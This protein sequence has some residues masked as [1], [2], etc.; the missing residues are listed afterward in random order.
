VEGGGHD[1]RA[2]ARFGGSTIGRTIECPG[3]AQLAGDEQSP[4][5]VYALEGTMAHELA[6]RCLT[7]GIDPEDMVDRPLQVGGE[8]VT[9]EMAEAVAVHVGYVRSRLVEGD[10]LLVEQKVSLAALDPPEDMW[11]MTDVAIL[12]PARNLL[13]VI[14][15]KHGAGVFVPATTP[16]LKYYGIGTLFGL[17]THHSVPEKVR[18]TVVQPRAFSEEGPIRSVDMTT[19]ELLD[20]GWALMDVVRTALAPDPPLRSGSHCRFCPAAAFCPALRRKTEDV[21]GS[22]LFAEDPPEQLPVPV[23]IGTRDLADLLDK[24]PLVETWVAAVR[25]RAR[26]V[27][28]AGVELPGWKLVERRGR[29]VW[30]DEE[31]VIATL[32]AEGFTKE[33]LIATKVLSPAKVLKLIAPKR[34]SELTAELTKAGLLARSP[35]EPGMVRSDDSRPSVEPPCGS[36]NLLSLFDEDLS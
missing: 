22:V 14:D 18:L 16:Q 13:E 26:E 2:H 3:W 24:L 17:P 9:A 33:Q 36:A 35:V 7:S 8:P 27:L 10:T 11:G 29:R 5:S 1:T 30:T 23:E 32:L 12:S 4:P 20:W 31:Q 19:A 6:E 15:Y 21:I 25:V 34:R 28:K